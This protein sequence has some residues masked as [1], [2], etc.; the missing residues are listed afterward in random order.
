VARSLAFAGII[1]LAGALAGGIAGA[2]APAAP[3]LLAAGDIAVCGSRGDEATAQLIRTRPGTVATLGDNVYDVGSQREFADCYD[4]S[5]GT[6][7]HRTR[8]SPGNHDY[9]TKGAKGYFSYFGKAA[10]GRKKGYYSYDLGAWHIIALNSNCPKIG[11]CG[12]KSPQG[13]WL[14]RDLRAH[15][16]ECTLAYWHH[17]LFSSGA[18]HGGEETMRAFW[19]ALYAAGADVVL[20]GHEHNYERFAPQD[21]QGRLDP[22]R[23]IRQFVVGTGGASHYGFAEPLPTSEKRIAHRFGVLKLTLHPTSYDWAF[24]P[25]GSPSGPA[26]TGTDDC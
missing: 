5:W 12:A 4:P 1:V 11:G 26:D 18:E 9:Y 3:V 6:F 16:A 15:P 10:G 20:A 7:K 13:R 14:R 19:K 2:A 23:G 8:P 24:I 17:P 22:E 21:P 25:T